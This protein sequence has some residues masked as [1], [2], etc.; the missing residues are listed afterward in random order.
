VRVIAK[1]TLRNFWSRYNDCEEYLKSWYKEA[2]D[3]HWKSPND[4][5]R[6]FPTASFLPE[7]RVVFNIKGNNYR[8]VVKINYHFGLV[9]IRFVGTHGQYNKINAITI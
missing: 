5:K 8:L 9:W 4:I 3:A 2:E 7:N 1:S 6:D